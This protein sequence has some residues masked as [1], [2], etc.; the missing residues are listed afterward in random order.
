MADEVES[1]VKETK[2]LSIEDE[3]LIAELL[4]EYNGI[5]AEITQSFKNAHYEFTKASMLMKSTEREAMKVS[6]YDLERKAYATIDDKF[7]LVEHTIVSER[8]SEKQK[9]DEDVIEKTAN[10]NEKETETDSVKVIP[11][12][13]LINGGFT[14]LGLKQTHLIYKSILPKLLQLINKRNEIYSKLGD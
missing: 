11:P 8:K 6:I 1:L 3:D 14:S 7:E 9:E 2:Q 10:S 5:L 4:N 12:L 13:K